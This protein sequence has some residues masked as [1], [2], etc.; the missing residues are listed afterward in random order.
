MKIETF[1][2]TISV[3]EYIEQYVN[4]E[5]FLE[6]CKE[7]NNY[8]CKWSCPSFDFDPLDYWNKYDS[9]RVVGKKIFLDETDKDNWENGIK[10]VKED[11]TKELFEE[12]EKNPG[13]ISLSAGSC[14]ICEEGQCTKTKGEPCKYPEKMRYSIEALGG[15]VGATASR[16]LGIDLQ[17]IEQGQVPDYFA[18]IGG[19]LTGISPTPLSTKRGL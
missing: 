16:L 13:S 18:L 11:L 5:D 10:Q 7:C 3:P 14:Q 12:E 17:W 8:D 4:V 19:L 9:F 6:K 1:E 2:R 15:D